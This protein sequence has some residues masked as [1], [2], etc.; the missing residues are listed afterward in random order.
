MRHF[1]EIF[2]KYQPLLLRYA[3]KF[4]EN[5]DDALNLV[6]DLFLAVFERNIYQGSEEYLRN[7]LFKSVRNHCLNYIKHKQVEKRFLVNRL[8][9]L[10]EIEI[11]YYSSG[12]K[13]LIEI[14]AYQNIHNAINSLSD[15]NKEII[16][17]SRFEGLKNKE[18]A[19]RLE[20]PVRTVE[21]RLFRALAQL[22][23]VLSGS[24]FIFFIIDWIKR[25]KWQK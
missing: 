25:K 14:E 22:R 18:I 6:Q 11:E 23:N 16:L 5:E 19:E 4:I 24:T 13:S 17:L 8:P 15:I 1:D 10:K 20:I 3:R 2:V 9:D 7:Y 21:T 12:E